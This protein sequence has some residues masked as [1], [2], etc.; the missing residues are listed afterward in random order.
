MKR[1]DV[2]KAI[3]TERD[4]QVRMVTDNDRPDIN[5]EMHVGD[6]L[7]AIRY[8]L[9]Q[10]THEWYYGSRPHTNATTYLRKIAALCVQAGEKNGMEER[11]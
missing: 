1:K 6:I 5:G 3:D 4:F 10:A 9:D 7:S 8:N 2:Y 11:K